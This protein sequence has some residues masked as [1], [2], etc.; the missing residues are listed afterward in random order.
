M[1]AVTLS[2]VFLSG[3][4]GVLLLLIFAFMYV[5]ASHYFRRISFR[6]FWI[7]HHL[8][9]LVY[10]LVKQKTPIHLMSFNSVR[11]SVLC[12]KKNS[13]NIV[14][15]QT[16]GDQIKKLSR[17]Y[18]DY[19]HFLFV[20]ISKRKS[21]SIIFCLFVLCLCVFCS[22]LRFILKVTLLA[23]TLDTGTVNTDFL[24]L[25]SFGRLWSTAATP[26]SRSPASTSTW[27]PLVSSSSWTSSS[28]STGR[29]WRSQWWKPSCCPQVEN[30]RSADPAQSSFISESPRARVHSAVSC[31]VKCS[32]PNALAVKWYV[33]SE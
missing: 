3:L 21:F 8:Y 9:V 4:T 27:S 33:G 20:C 25:I 17:N 24:S 13:W 30:L 22:L 23:G 15:M 26:S 10:V 11:A 29:R 6:G 5:F 12:T 28:A 32:L 18:Y 7:T 16:V 19:D 2:F 14:E 1:I 31:A